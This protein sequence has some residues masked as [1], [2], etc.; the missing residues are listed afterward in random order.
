[1]TPIQAFLKD[2]P[3]TH[4]MI[5]GFSQKEGYPV[6]ILVDINGNLHEHETFKIKAIV[7]W[8]WE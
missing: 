7:K 1:M 5:I 4:Y 8:Y 2:D 3:K 6:A